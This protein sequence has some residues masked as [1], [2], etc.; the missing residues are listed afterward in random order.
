M[1]ENTEKSNSKTPDKKEPGGKDDLD[2]ILVILKSVYI[3]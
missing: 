3:P 1:S 2:K